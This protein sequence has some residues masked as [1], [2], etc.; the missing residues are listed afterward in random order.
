MMPSPVSA[1]RRM[2]CVA[3]FALA[4]A[5]ASKVYTKMLVS[6]KNLPLIHLVP[7]VGPGRPHVLQAPHQR[8]DSCAPSCLCRILFQPLAESRVQR[9]VLRPCD[10]PCLLDQAFFRAAGDVFHAVTV[11]TISVCYSSRDSGICSTTL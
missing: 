11:Y 7:S 8:V 5:W 4:G 10:L 3:F 2:S 9:L 1:A 6:R